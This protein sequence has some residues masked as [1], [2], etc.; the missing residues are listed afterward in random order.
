MNDGLPRYLGESEQRR[1]EG[2]PSSINPSND[3]L[4]HFDGTLQST[5]GTRPEAGHDA[6]LLTAGLFGGGVEVASSLRYAIPTPDE[7]T[8]VVHRDS[9]TLSEYQGLT[10][11]QLEDMQPW[12]SRRV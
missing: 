3:H 11:Q 1:L 10:L 9:R 6:A 7:W 5:Q 12:R 4:F 8:V 2:I